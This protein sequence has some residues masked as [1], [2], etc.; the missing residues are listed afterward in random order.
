MSSEY[1]GP[2]LG[3]KSPIEPLGD[4]IPALLTALP[5]EARGGYV[6]GVRGVTVEPFINF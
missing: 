4:I 2:D 1:K 3:P 5:D 6:Q